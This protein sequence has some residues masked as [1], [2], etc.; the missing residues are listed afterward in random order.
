MYHES[1][2]GSFDNHVSAFSDLNGHVPEAGDDH[3]DMVWDAATEWTPE[4]WAEHVAGAVKATDV[5][6][7]AVG[8]WQRENK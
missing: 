8:E 5:A 1:N 7:E 4:A 2:L 6:N 3:A